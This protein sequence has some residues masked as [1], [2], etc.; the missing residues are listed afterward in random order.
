ML[1]WDILPLA[2]EPQTTRLP[3][4]VTYLTVHGARMADGSSPGSVRSTYCNS[5]PIEGGGAA[6]L[7]SSCAGM[8]NVMLSL[9]LPL[10]IHLMQNACKEKAGQLVVL[11]TCSSSR[12]DSSS[13]ACTSQ[14]RA[15]K[16][17]ELTKV[18]LEL[19]LAAAVVLSPGEATE[20]LAPSGR[21]AREGEA[22]SWAVTMT[23]RR[24]PLRN[25]KDLTE[26]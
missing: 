1:M 18:M 22:S 3:P 5:L 11:Q 19:S 26:A 7:L 13:A 6:S 14:R 25:P 16:G 24:S 2:V 4:K 23:H 10:Q 20:L 21:P 17:Q 12:P 9:L 15:S 8:S